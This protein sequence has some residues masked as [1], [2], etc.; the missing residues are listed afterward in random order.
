MTNSSKNW[1]ILDCLEIKYD[2][3]NLLNWPISVK[4]TPL[5]YRFPTYVTMNS[6]F[7]PKVTPKM[8]VDFSTCELAFQ[9]AIFAGSPQSKF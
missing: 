5:L 7:S 6:T 8:E 1:K 9:N 2:L 3:A 4:T